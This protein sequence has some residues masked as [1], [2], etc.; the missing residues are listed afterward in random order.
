MP[1]G[2][3][4]F[5]KNIQENKPYIIAKI[6]QSLDGCIASKNGSSQWISSV[7]SR[8]RVHILRSEVDAVMVGKG[9]VQKDNP[10]LTVRDVLGLNPFRVI[11]DAEMKLSFKIFS[12]RWRHNTIVLT[13]HIHAKK[14]KALN[15]IDAG[16]KVLAVELEPNGKLNIET[17]FRLMHEQFSIGSI[18]VEGGGILLSSIAKSQ[19]IDEIHFFIAPIILGHGVK[20]FSELEVGKLESALSFKTRAIAKSGPR[21]T[22]CI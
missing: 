1:M 7:E 17:A 18:M 21:S 20:S 5:S 9:T 6:A 8:R 2:K 11:T 3:S 22:R 16:V 13:S 19:L 14:K 10:E 4:V 12:D 15:L